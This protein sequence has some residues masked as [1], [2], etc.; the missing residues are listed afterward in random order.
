M[1]G[2]CGIYKRY[3][4]PAER[5]SVRRMRDLLS[6]RGPDGKGEYVEGEI[7]LGHRRLSVIDIEGGHQPMCNEDGRYWIVFNGEIYNFKDLRIDLEKRNHRFRTKCDTEVILHLF[8]DEGENCLSR[9]NGMFA[10]AIW[11]KLE[12][13]LFLARDRLGI[14]PLYYYCD[15]KN[16]IFASEIKSV[17]SCSETAAILNRKRVKEYLF[18][19]YIAGEETFFEGVKSLQPGHFI[20]VSANEM[21]V[22]RYWS[23]GQERGSD[24]AGEE[25]CERDI[26]F[27]LKESINK[28]LV[29]D[30]P[31]G[32]FCSGGIDSSL[33]TAMT[34]GMTDFRLS[35]YSIGFQEKD[36]DESDY[37][38]EVAKM[39]STIHNEVVVDNREFS[40]VLPKVIW[41]LDE[42]L[43]H[44][45]SVQIY[46]LSRFAKNYVT[47]ILT[48]EG[49]DEIFGGYPRY[50]IPKAISDFRKFPEFINK[51]AYSALAGINR[52][53]IRKLC[54]SMA[55]GTEAMAVN[56][57][58]WVRDE[59]VNSICNERET[60]DLSERFAR[61]ELKGYSTDDFIRS[62]LI[63]E[64]QTYLVS[65]LNRA[66][67]MS[68]AAG[69]ELRVPFLD[70]TFVQ[71]VNKVS[72]NY[73]L[74][75][76]KTKSIL[77]D[78]AR[79]FLPDS[80]VD[81][82]K[83]GFGN[84]VDA[85]LGDRKGLGRYMDVVLSQ[86]VKNLDFYRASSVEKL[87]SE[88]NDGKKHGSILWQLINFSIWYDTFF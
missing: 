63:L 26:L 17:V 87:I 53:K 7:G 51:A 79:N 4:S 33:V 6:H 86:K 46:L 76:L 34:S 20:K 40:D 49:A 41:Y 43:N 73:K 44:A 8:E 59:I 83:S 56:N 16:F 57:S 67:K 78:I 10:F 30:V 85:W 45:N 75:G 71:K 82:K 50:L 42:P 27:S 2:I 84:P 47:V 52:R 11:D 15:D 69:I 19:R 70:H 22:K 68:M 21:K 61:F 35:S 55:L 1:C 58:K 24:D 77:K 5:Q 36:Y 9:F 80:I 81:R 25:Y 3:G 12:K 66:D 29:S 60:L 48:G 64:Q 65:I 14:K 39:Y 37:A 13:T 32:C 88:Q 72:V 28:R 18:F 74:R 62:L 23:L 31:L 54:D 38:R